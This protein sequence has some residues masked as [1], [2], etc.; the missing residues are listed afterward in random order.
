M[1]AFRPQ[2]L[3]EEER[4]ELAKRQA[5]IDALPSYADRVRAATSKWSAASVG[6]ARDKLRSARPGRDR[7]IFCEDSEGRDVE[8]LLPRFLFPEATWRWQNLLCACGGCNGSKGSR[9]A[10]LTESGEYR[11]VSRRP[12]DPVVPPPPGPSAWIDPRVEDPMRLLQL[13]ILGESFYFLP[14]DSLSKED[15]ARVEWTVEECLELN[16][17]ESLVQARR[18]A[19]TNYRARLH[20]YAQKKGAGATSTALSRLRDDLREEN[21]PTVWAEI[22]RQREHLDGISALFDAVPEALGW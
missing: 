15:Q 17:R 12:R 2:D 6:P 9:H 19:F 3:T 16:K 10:I 18:H 22:K 4:S 11:D 14:R 21:H 1:L 8:H 20:E 5:T 7:C 13:D